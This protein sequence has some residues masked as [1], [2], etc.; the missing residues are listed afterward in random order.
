MASDQGQGDLQSKTRAELEQMAKQQDPNIAQS[1]MSKEEL[2][3]AL[4]KHQ[5]GN[6]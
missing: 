6:S 1:K 2:I 5:R 4:E 3:Q